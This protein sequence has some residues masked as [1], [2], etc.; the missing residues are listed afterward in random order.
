MAMAKEAK[1][2]QCAARHSTR[3]WSVGKAGC[4]L[5]S[6]SSSTR[7]ICRIQTAAG[8]RTILGTGI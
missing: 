5:I 2:T 1:D 8:A 4:A 3:T 6:G 7:Q